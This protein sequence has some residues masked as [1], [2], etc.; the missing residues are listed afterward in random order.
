MS[1]RIWKSK[2]MTVSGLV[3][4]GPGVV[5]GVFVVSGTPTIELDDAVT[6]TNSIVPAWQSVAATMYPLSAQAFKDGLYVNLVGTASIVV[7]YD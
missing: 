1:E 4:T 7:F 3:K 2:K 6:N 5:G